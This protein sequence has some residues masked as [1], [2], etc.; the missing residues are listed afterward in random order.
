MC[1]ISDAERHLKIAALSEAQ[2][3][4]AEAR[5]HYLE[6]A[7]IYVL[8]AEMTK[9][10]DLLIKANQ[11][12]AQAQRMREAKKTRGAEKTNITYSKQELAKRTLEELQEFQ[13]SHHHDALAEIRGIA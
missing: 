5:E 11:C 10:D 2:D 7:S 13:H 1:S 6:A 8:Q 12:Y 4:K 9:N 3:S